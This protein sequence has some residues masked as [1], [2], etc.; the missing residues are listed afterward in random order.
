MAV[1]SVSGAPRWI[2]FGLVGLGLAV[3]AL[4]PAGDASGPVGGGLAVLGAVVVFVGAWRQ[5][6]LSEA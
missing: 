6:S 2:G 3:V 5:G 1:D 4:E